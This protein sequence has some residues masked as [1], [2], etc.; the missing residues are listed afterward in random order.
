MNTWGMHGQV[1]TLWGSLSCSSCTLPLRHTHT[2]AYTHTCTQTS[3][4]KGEL[5]D[6][7]FRHHQTP[8]AHFPRKNKIRTHTNTHALLIDLKIFR[9]QKKTSSR[10]G[11]IWVFFF[12]LPS[13]SRAVTALHAVSRH[14]SVFFHFHDTRNQAPV[15][16]VRVLSISTIFC[17]AIFTSNKM[18]ET[19]PVCL[20]HFDPST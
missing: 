19:V 15:Y 9:H 4:D 6:F 12:S 17:F 16:H 5:V 18:T 2:H 13:W 1:D 3:M 11:S 8:T 14:S 20:R 10:G 7:Y